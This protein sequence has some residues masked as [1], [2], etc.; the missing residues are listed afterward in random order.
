M[1]RQK[2]ELLELMNQKKKRE[3]KDFSNFCLGTPMR[4]STQ[5]TNLNLADNSLKSITVDDST[6]KLI[7]QQFQYK[8][9]SRDPTFSDRYHLK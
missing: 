8:I 1:Q 4:I 7:F 2:V 5:Y 9:Y 3:K 6:I